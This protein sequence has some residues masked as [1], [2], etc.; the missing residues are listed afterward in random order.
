MGNHVSCA[1]DETH[2]LQ[3]IC[4]CPAKKIEIK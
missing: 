3:K 4:I 2:S 1:A